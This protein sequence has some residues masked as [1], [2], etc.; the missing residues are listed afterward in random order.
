MFN[1]AGFTHIGTEREFNQDRILIQ[2]IVSKDGLY[3]FEGLE[4]CFCFVADGIGGGPAGDLAA[5][6]VLENINQRIPCGHL[7]TVDELGKILGEINM[8]LLAMGKATPE[9]F[10]AGS[11]LVGLII[12]DGQFR[13]INAGD[14]Q[15]YMFRNSSLIKITEDQVFDPYQE[16]SPLISYFGGRHNQL[17]LDFD[18][19]L[20]GIQPDDIFLLSSDG[21]FKSL[22]VNQIK[23]VLS[24]SKPLAQKVKFLME[25]SINAGAEDNLSCILIEIVE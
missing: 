20:R 10:G 3:S 6:F 19:V 18:T 22:D 11:T 17:H 24:N 2:D 8:E 5:Q 9:Y 7:S 14:S 16:N 1:I 12:V 21:M 13:V 23:A 15:V 4:H 25:K